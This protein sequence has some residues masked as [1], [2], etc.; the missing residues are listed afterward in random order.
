MVL[1]V[2]YNK[3]AQGRGTI[4]HIGLYVKNFRENHNL[5]MQEFADKAGLSKGYISMLERG[6]H[7]QNNR[8]IVP[9]IETVNKIAIAMGISIDELLMQI[10]GEPTN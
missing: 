10:D 2:Y 1:Y 8:D 7:P 6:K 4:M 3:H 9:S 5:S